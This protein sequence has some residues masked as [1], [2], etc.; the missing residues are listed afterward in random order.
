MIENFSVNY[1]VYASDADEFQCEDLVAIAAEANEHIKAMYL[2]T[3]SL[4]NEDLHFDADFNFRLVG[5]GP[6]FRE[7]EVVIGAIAAF[8]SPDECPAGELLYYPQWVQDG[9]RVRWRKMPP[10]RVIAPGRMIP[11]DPPME[12]YT[13]RREPIVLF[14]RTLTGYWRKR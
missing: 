5:F 6:D 4:V 11:I 10:A 8:V 1:R 9:D 2:R 14:R 7:Y 3:M 13:F 12:D